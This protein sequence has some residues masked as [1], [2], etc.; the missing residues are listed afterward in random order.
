MNNYEHIIQGGVGALIAYCDKREENNCPVCV[1]SGNC[2]ECNCQ[3]GLR[4]WLEAEYLVDD[5]NERIIEDAT[6][7]PDD[8]WKC[9]GKSCY[10]CEHHGC[11]A[12]DMVLDLLARQRR[13]DG[14]ES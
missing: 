13:L 7:S 3:I 5:F 12:E 9:Q 14:V 8:Y 6:K 10:T 2:I 11:C 4:K 1:F